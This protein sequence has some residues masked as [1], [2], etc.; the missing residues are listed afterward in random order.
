MQRELQE[1]QVT[2]AETVHELEKTRALLAHQDSIAQQQQLRAER[3]VQ[4]AAELEREFGIHRQEF[5]DA[6][7]KKTNRIASLEKQIRDIACVSLTSAL[8]FGSVRVFVEAHCKSRLAGMGRTN[9]RWRRPTDWEP[10][11][12]TSDTLSWPVARIWWRSAS[13]R[14]KLQIKGDWRSV[15]SR[16]PHS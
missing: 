7:T 15:T 10:N 16:R 2:H 6:L 8:F 14:P 1:L 5:D 13:F 11:Q 12:S 3:W 4:K 9:T